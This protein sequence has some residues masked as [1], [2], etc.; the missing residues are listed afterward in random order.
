MEVKAPISDMIVGTKS[1]RDA[2]E[3]LQEK[4]IIAGR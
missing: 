2:K 1:G 3:T 4:Y